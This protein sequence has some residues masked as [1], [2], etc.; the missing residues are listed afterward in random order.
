MA[1]TKRT[2]AV[3]VGEIM[4][5]PCADGGELLDSLG[6]TGKRDN[7]ALIAAVIFEKARSGDM[8]CI[9]EI[10]HM[11]SQEQSGAAPVKIIDDVK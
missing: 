5:L 3:C 8:N 10:M 4:K 1:R 2:V 9:R 7:A 11:C 6:Y